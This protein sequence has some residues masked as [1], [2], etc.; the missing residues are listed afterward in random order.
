MKPTKK[1]VK[2]KKSAAML[3]LGLDGED[4]HTRIT[5]GENFVL[6]GGSEDTHAMMQETAIKVNEK[7]DRKGVKLEDCSPCDLASIFRE[8]FE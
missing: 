8:I 4:G 2:K 7:L 3:G 1:S 5:K 6:Y